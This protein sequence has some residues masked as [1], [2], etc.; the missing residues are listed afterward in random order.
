MLRCVDPVIT[1]VT[2]LGYRDP[3]VIA[4]NGDDNHLTKKFKSAMSGGLQ[5]DH[6]LILRAFEAWDSGRKGNWPIHRIMSIP[7]LQYIKD[8]RRT[9][10]DHLK[11]CNLRP[12][13][14]L[15]S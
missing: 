11:A 10:F 2:S 1:I 13:K 15:K 6:H 3:F 4:S 7:T 12:S 14:F 8:V 5:S 9:I